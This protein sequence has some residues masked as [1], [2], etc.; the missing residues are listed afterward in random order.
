ML[1]FKTA[2]ASGLSKEDIMAIKDGAVRRAEMLA[3]PQ[4]FPELNEK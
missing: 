1:D 2:L 3:H 4:F